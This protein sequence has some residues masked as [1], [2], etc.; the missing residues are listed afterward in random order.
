MGQLM[1]PETFRDTLLAYTTI[2]A[3]FLMFG[4]GLYLE[5]G[6]LMIGAVLA[7]CILMAG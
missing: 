5:S 4:I 1:K 3:I 7:F 6:L 2:A